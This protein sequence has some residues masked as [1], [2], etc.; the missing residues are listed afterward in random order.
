MSIIS[1]NTRPHVISQMTD[2]ED[3]A[4]L[5][6]VECQGLTNFAPMF[7][8]LREQIERDVPQLQAVGIQ[9]LRP[10]V[11]VLTDGSPT[12]PG[13]WESALDNVLDK[14]WKS[15]PNT[16]AYGFGGAKEEVLARIATVAAYRAE[17]GNRDI[18]KALT[19]AL[20]SLLNSLVAS[21]RA[22]QLQVPKEVE[23]YTTVPLDIID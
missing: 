17:P 23:G 19:T 11:F 10:V 12:D 21:A 14:G 7:A 15:H 8:L 18:A 20:T 16:I 9:V 13:T 2:I 4:G 3:V 1:F 22:Q 5:P 6:Q